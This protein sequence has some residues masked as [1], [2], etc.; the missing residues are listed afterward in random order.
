MSYIRFFVYQFLLLSTVFGFNIF[1][2]GY[3][4]KPFTLVDFIAICIGLPLLMIG[5]SLI[6]KIFRRFSSTRFG[7]RLLLLV[8][9]IILSF[10]FIGVVEQFF[11]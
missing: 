3:I 4:S 8:P 11:F 5:F 1:I 6:W 7:T 9:T 10:L 2:D